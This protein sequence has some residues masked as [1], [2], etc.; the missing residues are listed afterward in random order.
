MTTMAR[1]PEK[2]K[3]DTGF[4]FVYN[5]GMHRSLSIFHSFIIAP[6][7][8]SSNLRVMNGAPGRRGLSF[9]VAL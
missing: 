9:G 2:L 4:D 6:N 8:G 1:M 3:L 5:R 7:L